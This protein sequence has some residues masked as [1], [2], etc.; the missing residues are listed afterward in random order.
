[1]PEMNGIDFLKKIKE[2]HS[3]VKVIIITQCDEPAL[4]VHLVTLGTDGFLLKDTSRYGLEK[5]ILTSHSRWA[6][7][8]ASPRTTGFEPWKTRV[9]NLPN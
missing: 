1:M 9:N 8:Q 6:I 4:I 3:Q 7:L 5:A 2:L